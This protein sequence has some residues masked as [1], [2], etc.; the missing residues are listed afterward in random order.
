MKAKTFLA[1]LMILCASCALA[2]T[3]PEQIKSD[4][5]W[6][7]YV[8]DTRING[9]KILPGRYIQAAMIETK[10]GGKKTVA[11][12]LAVIEFERMNSSHDNLPLYSEV[13][14][15]YEDGLASFMSTL[16]TSGEVPVLRHFMLNKDG[17][18]VKV[19]EGYS[20]AMP[21]Q[22]SGYAW[23]RTAISSGNISFL[24]PL[25]EKSYPENWYKGSWLCEGE[26]ISFNFDDDSKFQMSYTDN[27]FSGLYSV[28]GNIISLT[29]LDGQQ[30][31]IYT[32]YDKEASALVM[33][34]EDN[35]QKFRLKA[36]TFKRIFKT[37]E[38][39]PE[40]MKQDER[41]GPFI[42]STRQKAAKLL[43]GRYFQSRIVDDASGSGRFFAPTNFII[44]LQPLSYTHNNLPAYSATVDIYH[45]GL[46]SFLMTLDTG[47][48]GE[49]PILRMH[50]PS[51]KLVAEDYISLVPS[52]T[53]KNHV[54]FQAGRQSHN[55]RILYPLNNDE[56]FPEGWYKGS[57]T[58]KKKAGSD[59]V[60]YT[61]DD[62]KNF[63]VNDKFMGFY[64]VSD[65][66]IV[67]TYE[68]TSRE[69][70]FAMYDRGSDSLLMRFA[71]GDGNLTDNAGFFK[72]VRVTPSK[73]IERLKKILNSSTGLNRVSPEQA[74]EDARFK[75]AIEYTKQRGAKLLTGRY[76]Y[77]KEIMNRGD[78]L[79]RKILAP[80]EIIF[81][82]GEFNAANCIFPVDSYPANF[83]VCGDNLVQ[84]YV[85]FDTSG[86][87]PVMKVTADGQTITEDYTV[88]GSVTS[89]VSSYVWG[90]GSVETGE[91]RYLY[92][93]NDA[94]FPEGW[95]KGTWK[96]GNL[97]F[98]FEG[99]GKF[100]T[101]GEL[102]GS[103]TVSDNRIAVKLS[104][105][106]D[107]VLFAMYSPDLDALVITIKNDREFNG[108]D[109]A[110]IFTRVQ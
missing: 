42:E 67:L 83:D 102:L 8:E 90:L 17:E 5:V 106:S 52:F 86:L 33:R 36:E 43:P 3:T 11:P 101:N 29:F 100:Y 20:V 95:Y 94:W 93:I 19:A 16:D 108:A 57:W 107:N 75:P 76:V 10:Q 62:D 63:Y 61:F 66:R 18:L 65:N 35:P 84:A 110:G 34:F 48:P 59:N 109:T 60:K 73:E 4:P 68:D 105:G 12:T 7:P 51:K 81:E 2:V 30:G 45:Q 96:C 85:T 92:P 55:V 79:K 78:P 28:S 47:K 54:I 23:C 77:T 24:F 22:D 41:F 104:D 38:L 97:T 71:D 103:Y 50:Y 98:T 6:G 82:V 46:A 37:S 1:A 49:V 39:T 9:E 15:T 74:A 14:N 21:Y 44:E 13:L 70:I 91:L 53:G 26:G 27:E 64:A 69:T 87:V 99:T 56:L 32:L 72:R 58:G 40:Q 31:T 88:V 89:R 25:N 80:T